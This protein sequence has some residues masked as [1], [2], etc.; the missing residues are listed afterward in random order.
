VFVRNV[1]GSVAEWKKLREARG[2]RK[3]TLLRK[4]FSRRFKRP[5][6]VI[7]KRFCTHNIECGVRMDHVLALGVVFQE[8]VHLV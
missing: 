1:L 2:E 3:E 6:I 5:W 7:E 4:R 8:V